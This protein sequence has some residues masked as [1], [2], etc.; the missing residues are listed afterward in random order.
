M[1]ENDEVA[2]EEGIQAMPTFK[3]YKHGSPVGKEKVV[4]GNEAAL[5][6]K[7]DAVLKLK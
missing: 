7:I 3:F 5:K 2:E 4:G 1:D 6:A